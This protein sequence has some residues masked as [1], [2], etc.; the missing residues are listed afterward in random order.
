MANKLDKEAQET[1]TIITIINSKLQTNHLL[2]TF[3][4]PFILEFTHYHVS[5]EQTC[6]TDKWLHLIFL[7]PKTQ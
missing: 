6:P 1:H 4:R 5:Q 7:D 3:I 2:P